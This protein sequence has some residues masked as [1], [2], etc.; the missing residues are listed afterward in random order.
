M[1]GAAADPAPDRPIVLVVDDE[2]SIADAVVEILNRN[3]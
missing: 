2:P 3:G 1:E